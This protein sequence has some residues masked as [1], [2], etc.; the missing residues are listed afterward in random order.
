MAR[1]EV[2]VLTDFVFEDDFGVPIPEGEYRIIRFGGR[3]VA[4]QVIPSDPERG[5]MLPTVTMRSEASDKAGWD[6]ERLVL[7]RFFSAL[8][9][10]LDRA[11]IPMIFGLQVRPVGPGDWV[12]LRQSGWPLPL[13]RFLPTPRDLIVVPDERLALALALRREGRSSFSPFHRFL[14]YWNALDVVFDGDAS[15]RD[16]FIET[17]PRRARGWFQGWDAV[18]PNLV[19]YFS[20]SIRNAIAHA[21]PRGGAQVL[22]PDDPADFERL[23]RDSRVLEKMLRAA[24]EDRW[25]YPVSARPVG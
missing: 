6:A 19:G 1:H 13:T 22:D 20:T 8:S 2:P 14:A 21:F 23:Y 24:I 16:R 9:F 18:P 7:Q 3:E 11:I 17:R 15:R 12:T 4:W 10:N 25:P 5:R